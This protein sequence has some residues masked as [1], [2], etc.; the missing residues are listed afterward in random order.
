MR[1]NFFKYNAYVLCAAISTGNMLCAM[2]ADDELEP[3]LPRTRTIRPKRQR[4]TPEVDEVVGEVK[5]EQHVVDADVMCRRSHDQKKP[6]LTRQQSLSQRSDSQRYNEEFDS[7][8]IRDTRERYSNALTTTGSDVDTEDEEANISHVSA[9]K[10]V[11]KVQFRDRVSVRGCSKVV[12]DEVVADSGTTIV[13]KTTASYHDVLKEKAKSDKKKRDLKNAMFTKMQ[14]EWKTIAEIE[15]HPVFTYKFKRALNKIR[16]GFKKFKEAKILGKNDG[17]LTG[18]FQDF[19]MWEV[20]YLNPNQILGDLVAR[21]QR[22]GFSKEV[23]IDQLEAAMDA[24]RTLH[25]EALNAKRADLVSANV[26]D[27]L[28]QNPTSAAASDEEG[29]VIDDASSDAG[30]TSSILYFQDM[31][32]MQYFDSLVERCD[33]VLVTFK[34]DL[35]HLKSKLGSLKSGQGLQRTGSKA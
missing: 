25:A 3:L 27:C 5:V 8:T 10:K 2:D 28:V 16:I 31:T 30:S 35:V 22:S 20:Q 19:S 32:D 1:L 23:T 11:K 4:S 12:T 26:F 34:E 21:L 7:Q 14:K 9:R 33:Q 15:R 24:E 13:E 6:I 29:T 18:V 17:S